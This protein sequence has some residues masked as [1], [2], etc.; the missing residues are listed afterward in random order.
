MISCSWWL[1]LLDDDFPCHPGLD[2]TEVRVG[3][4]CHESVG[5]ALTSL[6]DG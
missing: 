2:R 6:Q 5:K 4:R 1:M 3:A